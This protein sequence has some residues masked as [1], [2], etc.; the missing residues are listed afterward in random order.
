MGRTS[1][2]Y[3]A[4]ISYRNTPHDR[5]WAVWLLNQIES[6]K[7]PKSLIE[8]GFPKRLGKVFRDDDEGAASSNLTEQIEN[9]LTNS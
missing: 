5:K 6:Y 1:F 8:N 3:R 7:P 9:A 4:F 2:K